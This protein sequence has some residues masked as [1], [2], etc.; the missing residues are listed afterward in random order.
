MN[1]TLLKFCVGGLAGVGLGLIIGKYKL[2]QLEAKYDELE[3][4]NICLTSNCE[5][6]QMN[7]NNLKEV[8]KLYCNLL[9]QD[10]ED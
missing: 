10:K 5:L 6:L 3:L 2:D 4:Q 1:S 8:N 9:L 7:N